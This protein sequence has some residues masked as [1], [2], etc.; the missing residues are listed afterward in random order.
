[1]KPRDKDR[2][3]NRSPAHIKKPYIKNA[4][5]SMEYTWHVEKKQNE[6]P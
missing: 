4:H 2:I 6:H 1:M 3:G 5:M